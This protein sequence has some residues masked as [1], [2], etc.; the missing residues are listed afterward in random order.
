MKWL[1]CYLFQLNDKTKRKFETKFTNK[2]AIVMS[3]KTWMDRS[4]HIRNP[5]ERQPSVFVDPCGQRHNTPLRPSAHGR[6]IE[7][8]LW[9]GLKIEEHKLDKECWEGRPKNMYNQC[10]DFYTVNYLPKA[11]KCDGLTSFIMQMKCIVVAQK[12]RYLKDFEFEW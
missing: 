1:W 5:D 8:C 10:M 2:V 6:T 11:L 9:Y 3:H 7:K 4:K 12:P